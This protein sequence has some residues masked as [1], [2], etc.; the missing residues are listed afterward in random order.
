MEYLCCDYYYYY[1]C[2]CLLRYFVLLRV[3][4]YIIG[5]LVWGGGEGNA[6]EKKRRTKSGV[7]F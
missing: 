6:V 1:F 7:R 3:T 5:Q 4:P 2:C